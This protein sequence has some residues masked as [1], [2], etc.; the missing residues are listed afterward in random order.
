MCV[1]VCV[2]VC[3][4]FPPDNVLFLGIV[5]KYVEM[6]MNCIQIS[7]VKILQHL[8]NKNKMCV[9]FINYFV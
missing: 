6:L 9:F 4:F 2:C 5:K 8:K 7:C 3:F 1:C